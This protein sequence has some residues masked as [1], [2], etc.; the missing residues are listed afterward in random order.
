MSDTL[1][2]KDSSGQMR[3]IVISLICGAAAASITWLIANALVKPELEPATA[4]V[5]YRQMDGHGFVLW[6]A[7]IAFTIVLAAAL[8]IQNMVAKKKWRDGLVP[9]A[10]VVS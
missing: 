4:R 8:A 10:K 1:D 3:R 6:A 7:G 2:V 5:S 9:R